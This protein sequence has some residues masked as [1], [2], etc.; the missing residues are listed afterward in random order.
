[1]AWAIV[2]PLNSAGRFEPAWGPMAPASAMGP[3][4]PG[5]VAGHPS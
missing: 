3:G 5:K 2:P 4:V 1:M